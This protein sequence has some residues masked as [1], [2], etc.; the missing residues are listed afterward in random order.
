MKWIFLSNY[1]THHQ[2]PICEELNALNNGNFAFLS[3]EKFEE[4]RKTL[5]WNEQKDV[6]FVKDCN[7]MNEQELLSAINDSEVLIQ[8]VAP[9]EMINERLRNKKIILKYAERVF[10]KG[11]QP[12]R[13]FPRLFLYRKNYGKY[14]SFYLMCASAYTA[15]DYVIHGAFL[16]RRYKWGYFPQTN[17]YDLDLLMDSKEP[18]KL[19]WC[20]RFL[21]WKHPDDAVRVAQ[22]LKKD[23]YNFTLDIIGTG[24]MQQ[25]L[26]KMVNDSDL[27]DCV[28]L[29]GSKTPEEVRSYMEKSGIYLF[30][31]DFN[32]GWGAVV[33]EAMN[34]GC[35]VVA[36][37]AAGSVPYL[38]K[39]K[40]NGLIYKNGD[41]DGL[42]FHI[43]AL[44]DNPDMQKH[45]G[46]KAYHTIT[47]L[48]NAKVAAKRL[49][50]LV[51]EINDH[52]Y[53]DLYSDGPCSK[54][55]VIRNN[56]FRG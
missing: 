31:S 46:I 48:W 39:N 10:K 44:L 22:R 8:G 41:V 16:K 56:W 55:P 18:S 14:K 24:D 26:E 2:K 5:G 50:K 47:D 12:L 1:Y 51:D 11:Y 34:S 54:A 43:K 33:N 17:E 6:P 32:E 42:Y 3:T 36:S 52:G 7:S 13:W 9:L 23:G 49:V 45:I 20:G 25:Q 53:C 30:T 21:D 4:D 37:H 15:V 29:L 28:H 40:D 27:S 38:I 19:L 35:A